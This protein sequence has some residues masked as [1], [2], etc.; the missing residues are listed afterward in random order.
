MTINQFCSHLFFSNR[1]CDER[2][3]EETIPLLSHRTA[4]LFT[5]SKHEK[6]PRSKC[7]LYIYRG[8]NAAPDFPQANARVETLTPFKYR[9]YSFYQNGKGRRAA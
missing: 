2:F 3:F 4:R 9:I 8:D 5:Q 6:R 1:E 7:V